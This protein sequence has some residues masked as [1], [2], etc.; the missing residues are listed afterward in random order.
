MLSER[1]GGTGFHLAFVLRRRTRISVGLGDQSVATGG[2]DQKRGEQR[3]PLR[4]HDHARDS[5]NNL[6]S[7][8]DSTDQLPATGTDVPRSDQGADGRDNSIGRVTAATEHPARN[9]SSAYETTI[10]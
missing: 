5:L 8:T 9:R 3:P 2:P 7:P 6:P 4:G 10:G 1:K